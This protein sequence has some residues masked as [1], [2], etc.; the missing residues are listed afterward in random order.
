MDVTVVIPNYNGMNYIGACLDSLLAGEMTPEILVVDNGSAD[1]SA[2]Y[3]KEN[4]P[5][6]RLHCFPQNTGFCTAVNTGIR[7]AETEYVI[8]LNNDTAV[9]K[10]FAVKLYEAIKSRKDAFSVSSRMLSMKEPDRIDDA[11]DLYCAL[12]WAFARGKG[13]PAESCKKPAEVFAACG[14]ASIY[15][16]SVFDVIGYFDENHFAYLEDIDIGYR[17]KLSGFHNYYAPEAVVYHAGSASSGSR[18]NEFKTRLA[19]RN[20]IYL[21]CKNMPFLQILLNLIF[22]LPGFAVKTLFFIKKGMGKIYL[23]GLWEGIR[24]SLSSKGRQQKVRFRLECLGNYVKVQLE[25]WYNILRLAR[26]I[27]N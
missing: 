1:G 25:L 3:I 7:M 17:A 21:I 20:S 13:R 10:D 9:E 24:L 2:A 15:R 14:G 6:V 16:K 23:T 26:F 4:Y 27:E 19:A 8:L 18:Y 11:G 5:K 12:G 22:L